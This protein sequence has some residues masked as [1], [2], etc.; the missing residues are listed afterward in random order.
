ML[1]IYF[2]LPIIP[3]K[4]LTKFNSRSAMLRNLKTLL[5]TILEQIQMVQCKLH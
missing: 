5:N 3:K 1:I 2:I 4:I